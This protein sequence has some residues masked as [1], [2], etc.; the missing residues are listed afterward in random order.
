MDRWLWRTR[1]LR[2]GEMEMINLRRL[3]MGDDS[4]DGSTSNVTFETVGFLQPG[5]TLAGDSC[6]FGVSADGTTCLS[7]ASSTA[8]STPVSAWL[9][10]NAG[11]LTAIAALMGIGAYL[12]V[13]R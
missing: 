13:K 1:I 5:D 11:T 8:T 7:S 2:G 9:N 10:N 12:M 6:V 4:S 3:G